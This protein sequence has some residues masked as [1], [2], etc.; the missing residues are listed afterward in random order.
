M[1]SYVRAHPANG[2]GRKLR[3]ETGWSLSDLYATAAYFGVTVP[4][5]LPQALGE[6][7]KPVQVSWCPQRGSNPRPMENK[8]QSWADRRARSI[9]P[10]PM[11]A[12]VWQSEHQG[13]GPIQC[14]TYPRRLARPRWP[15]DHLA[16][17]QRSTTSHHPLQ[18]APHRVLRA[19]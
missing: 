3:G 7:F 4:Q 8:R 16:A 12:G 18:E 5:L 1:M 15:L 2:A 11:T 6:G 13:H 17:S 14:K 10:Q 19:A 9:Y